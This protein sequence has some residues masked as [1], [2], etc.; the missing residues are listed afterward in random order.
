MAVLA[1]LFSYT[2]FLRQRSYE[3]HVL[4][5]WSRQEYGG[6]NAYEYAKM[7][8]VHA[9]DPLQYWNGKLSQSWCGEQ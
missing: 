6:T 4:N 5:Y 2:G 1:V 3:Y 8:K 9:P 7:K